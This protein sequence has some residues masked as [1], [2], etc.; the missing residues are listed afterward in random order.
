MLYVPHF[1]IHSSDDGY[2]GWFFVLARILWILPGVIQ[3]GQKV[4]IFL[5]IWGT[6]SLMSKLLCQFTCPPTVSKSSS[7]NVFINTCHLTMATHSER[8]EKSQ[9]SLLCIYWMENYHK[10][11]P[12]CS[13]T[14]CISSSDNSLFFQI[15][16]P[17]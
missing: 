3:L 7:S 1:H 6:A 15:H 14:T 9:S 5:D 4:D 10:H 8:W 2:L 13:L 12:K 16:G 17:F 11:L